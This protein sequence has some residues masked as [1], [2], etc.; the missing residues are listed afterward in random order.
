MRR[1]AVVSGHV[2]GVGYRYFVRGRA[3]IRDVSPS[4]AV[5]HCFVPYFER[6]MVRRG[7]KQDTDSP[8]T[9]GDSGAVADS[10][11][12]STRSGS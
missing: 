7:A 3:E 2:Q 12:T 8:L 6:I 9:D 10:A 4:L 5:W 11:G 1:V